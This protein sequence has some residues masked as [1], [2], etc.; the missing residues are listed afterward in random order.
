MISATFCHVYHAGTNVI[1]LIGESKR[2]YRR[3]YLFSSW[4]SRQM[5]THCGGLLFRARSEIIVYLYYLFF[6]SHLVPDIKAM[7]SILDRFGTLDFRVWNS[8]ST[9]SFLSAK[10]ILTSKYIFFSILW[11]FWKYEIEA[12]LALG[13]WTKFLW[14]Q[15]N[16]KLISK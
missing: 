2:V 14:Y 9:Y 8:R 1:R 15:N 3:I 16:K 6:S 13:T 5:M 7:A 12:S 11:W 4:I 10:N